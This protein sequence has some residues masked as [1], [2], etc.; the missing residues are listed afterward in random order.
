MTE[1][2]IRIALRQEAD[3][4]FEVLF[5]DSTS[6]PLH[7]DEPEPLG[8]GTGPNPARL[9]GT[10]VANCLAAS[11]LFALRKF[12]NKPEPMQASCTLSPERNADGR[13]RIRRIEV[14]LRLG[15]PWS[16]LKHAE[17]AL[18]QF[19][20][21]CIVTQSV[22]GGIDVHVHTVDSG[23]APLARES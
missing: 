20:D 3:Y 16:S 7:T 6:A 15:V 8:H 2:P 17:R 1:E 9:L 18:A 21:F 11:L 12:G 23:G 10:A 19:E 13:W 5:E 14:E 4:R 22:R